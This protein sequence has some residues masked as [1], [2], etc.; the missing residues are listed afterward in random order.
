MGFLTRI[1]QT[2]PAMLVAVLEALIVLVVA[3]GLGIT[4]EQIGAILAFASLALG[5]VT[6]AL[7]TPVVKPEA[8]DDDTDI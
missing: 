4:P 8:A 3:F 6:R 7:V 1:A 2:E 5:L